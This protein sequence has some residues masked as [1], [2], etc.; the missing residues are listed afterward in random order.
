MLSLVN[1]YERGWAGLEREIIV[2]AEE[3]KIIM[4]QLFH[5]IRTRHY[6]IMYTTVSQGLATE[7]SLKGFN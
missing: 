1:L 6:T 2:S 3:I 5:A 7:E 4:E